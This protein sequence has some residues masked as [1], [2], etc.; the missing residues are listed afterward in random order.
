[1]KLQGIEYLKPLFAA[2]AVGAVIAGCSA[3]GGNKPAPTPSPTPA[4]PAASDL[5]VSVDKTSIADTGAETATITA[6]AVDANRNVV[7]GVPVTIVPDRNGVVTTSG[8]STSATGVVNG[9]LGIGGDKSN[10]TIDVVVTSGTITKTVKVDVVGAQL[11]ASAGAATAGQTATVQYQLTDKNNG[12]IANEPIVI[13]L[14]GTATNGTTD[15]NGLYTYSYTVPA[16]ATVSL[17]AT[18]AGVTT[19]TSVTTSSSSTAAATGTVTSASVAANPATVN[20]NTAG[21]TSNFVT[22][23][24]LFLGA[25]NAPIQYVRVRFDLNG[26]PSGIGGT[27]AAGSG[28][29]YTDANGVAQTTYTPGTRGSGNQQLT[30]RACWSET[31]FAAG[32]CPNAATANVTVAQSGVSIS[33][34]NNGKIGNDDTKAVYNLPYTVQVVDSVG[35]PIKGVLVTGSVDL[36]RYYRGYWDGST[37]AWKYV[38][39]NVCDNEDINRNNVLETYSNSQKED[40]NGSGKI[41]PYAADAAITPQS[42]GSDTTDAFGLAYFNLQYGQ[43]VAWWDD[44][45]LTFSAQVS[46]TEGKATTS[47][48]L[49]VPASLI[50]GATNV[51]L[52]F[53]ESPYNLAPP[54]VAP[55]AVTTVT[56]MDPATSRSGNLCQAQP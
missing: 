11:T 41:E 51:S 33:I 52:P 40:Q 3:G 15:G 18:A 55:A 4:P 1:M 28:Y 46:G 13:T 43:N 47:G 45:T 44:F 14:N 10:R 54:N 17:S 39:L 30:V 36:P 48:R 31:D 8:S 25:G 9:V 7:A 21:S 12:S 27:L 42:A 26:D 49:G 35:Q 29:V 2:V 24:G 56:V 50:N 22:V 37:G 32:T 19:Q 23:R 53:Q 20:V 5:V 6:T 38:N 34:F 16:T